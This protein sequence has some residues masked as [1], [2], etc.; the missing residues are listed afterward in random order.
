MDYAADPAELD[1]IRQFALLEETPLLNTL[2]AE[3]FAGEY[4]S[5]CLVDR[6]CMPILSVLTYHS[7]LALPLFAGVQEYAG[8]RQTWHSPGS[9]L[10]EVDPNYTKRMP[11][12]VETD[13]VMY[14][15]IEKAFEYGV[16]HGF[17]YRAKEGYANIWKLIVVENLADCVDIIYDLMDNTPRTTPFCELVRKD[18]RILFH[19]I[20]ILSHMNVFLTNHIEET[21]EN[22]I[23][24]IY[25]VIRS[26][27]HLLDALL[28][29]KADYDQNFIFL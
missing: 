8:Y 7:H 11:K 16:K 18:S 3:E 15:T 23:K 9:Y 13:P 14:E 12:L 17:V 4:L 26:Q 10:D 20:S 27:R 28:G 1:R 19:E 24:N 22:G 6:G 25:R 2:I 21:D 29:A 5:I